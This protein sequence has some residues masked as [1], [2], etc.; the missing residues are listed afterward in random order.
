MR[1]LKSKRVLKLFTVVA[2]LMKDGTLFYRTAEQTTKRR[3]S[4]LTVCEASIDKMGGCAADRRVLLSVAEQ[5][6]QVVRRYPI[7]NTI[8]KKQ[9]FVGWSQMN[10]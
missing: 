1:F 4:C 5:F 2:V 8:G 7:Q 6:T 3:S 10:W 9:H